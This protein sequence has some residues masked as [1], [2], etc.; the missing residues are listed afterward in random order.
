MLG[1]VTLLASD[2]DTEDPETRVT[3]SSSI[4]TAIGKRGSF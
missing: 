1:K 3:F 2:P 4:K